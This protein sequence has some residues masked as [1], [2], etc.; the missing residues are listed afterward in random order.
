MRNVQI[1]RQLGSKVVSK[2]FL[3][4]DLPIGIAL[5]AGSVNCAA[6][7]YRA[8]YVKNRMKKDNVKV[9]D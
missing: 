6:I 2:A 7:E 4:W 9:R 1:S 8:V 3:R 5:R